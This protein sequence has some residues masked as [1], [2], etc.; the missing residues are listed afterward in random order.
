MEVVHRALEAWDIAYSAALDRSNDPLIDVAHPPLTLKQAAEILNLGKSTV[1]A[2]ARRGELRSFR[3]P[4]HP[5][6][7][8]I[9][10]EEITRLLAE[11]TTERRSP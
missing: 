6:V 5:K 8:R 1:S 11:R 7:I 9:P 4:S 2:L 3:L 10:H